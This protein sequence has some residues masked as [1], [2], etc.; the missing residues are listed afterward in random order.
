[1]IFQGILTH[2]PPDLLTHEGKVAVVALYAIQ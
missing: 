1:M 2:N